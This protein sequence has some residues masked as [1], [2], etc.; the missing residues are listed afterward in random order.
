MRK[1]KTVRHLWCAMSELLH[2]H[3]YRKHYFIQRYQLNRK[4][5]SGTLMRYNSDTKN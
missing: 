3:K 1:V 4:P 5:T 2:S